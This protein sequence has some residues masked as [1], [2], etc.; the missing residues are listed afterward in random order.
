MGGRFEWTEGT[1]Q[2]G[3]SISDPTTTIADSW[4]NVRIILPA[5]FHSGSIKL[6]FDGGFKAAEYWD[7]LKE[8]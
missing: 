4:R 2:W 1:R 8:C 6:F 3:R 7:S 5:D